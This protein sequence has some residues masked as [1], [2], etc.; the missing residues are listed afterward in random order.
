V[1]GSV[2]SEESHAAG[3]A[4]VGSTVGSLAFEQ[5]SPDTRLE[6]RLALHGA[7]EVVLRD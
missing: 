4:A 3:W 7:E 5:V 6:H 2:A 1:F